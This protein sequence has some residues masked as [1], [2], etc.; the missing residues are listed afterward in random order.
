VIVLGK[1]PLE[2]DVD[3]TA[4]DSAS[5][6]VPLY[7]IF[8]TVALPVNAKIYSPAERVTVPWLQLLSTVP[9]AVRFTAEKE[10]NTAPL[11]LY[12]PQL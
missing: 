4:L 2:L 1:A 7:A 10:H 6:A 11:V 8:A 9:P 12:K 3:D 5:G